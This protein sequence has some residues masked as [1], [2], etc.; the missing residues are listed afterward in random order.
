MK[1]ILRFFYVFVICFCIFFCL[2]AC[3]SSVLEL[4][5]AWTP[6]KIEFCP[7]FFS[8]STPVYG[9]QLGTIYNISE[10]SKGLS[11]SPTAALKDFSGLELTPLISQRAGTSAGVF[12]SLF[13]WEHPVWFSSSILTAYCVAVSQSFF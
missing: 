8:D 10:G 7:P 9:L 13:A 11:I 3:S 12:I 1:K 4:D 5:S 6:V 2:C